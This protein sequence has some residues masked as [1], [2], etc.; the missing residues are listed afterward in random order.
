VPLVA[1]IVLTTA[2]CALWATAF[3]LAGMLAGTAWAAISSLLGKVLLG[4]GLVVL[5]LS[6]SRVQRVQRHE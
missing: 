5:V 3:V 1:F 6:L 4:V 2:G